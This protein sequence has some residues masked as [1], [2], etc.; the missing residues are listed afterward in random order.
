M[1]NE[2]DNDSMGGAESNDPDDEEQDENASMISKKSKKSG[3]SVKD[4][5]KPKSNKKAK[6]EENPFYPASNYDYG[7]S[8]PDKYE[9]PKII[10]TA[11][12]LEEENRLRGKGI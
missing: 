1:S 4:P 8:C 5:F 11:K 3:A 9:G 2:F 10:W 12:E 7:K 6:F